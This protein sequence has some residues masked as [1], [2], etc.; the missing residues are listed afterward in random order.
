MKKSY[1]ILLLASF[2]FMT[3][4]SAQTTGV[5]DTAPPSSSAVVSSEPEGKDYTVTI[6]NTFDI[7]GYDTENTEKMIS[8]NS[9]IYDA[10]T[11]D[12][13]YENSSQI[14]KG[15]VLNVKFTDNEGS[16]YIVFDVKVLKS[17]KGELNKNDLITVS[18]AGGYICLYDYVKKA[19]MEDRFKD[20][21]AAEQ[22]KKLLEDRTNYNEPY[23][24]A[25][26]ILFL[27][28]LDETKIKSNPIPGTYCIIN[29]ESTIYRT[30]KNGKLTREYNT[31]IKYGKYKKDKNN[32]DSFTEEWFE[33]RAKALEAKRAEESQAE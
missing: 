29:G 19:N 17:Y 27:P 25:G 24:T 26:E 4:C 13:M 3:A 22:K 7:S 8:Q 18:T 5:N 6:K 10:M 31:L 12:A 33:Q 23:P 20:I 2:V 14:I 15:E 21:P 32:I 16:P 30:D 11:V 28:L 1:L 9:Y